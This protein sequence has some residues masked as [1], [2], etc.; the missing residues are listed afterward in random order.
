M[1]MTL[2]WVLGTVLAMVFLVVAA[3]NVW[4]VI[5]FLVKRERNSAVPLVG[6]LCGVAACFLLPVPLAG[7][8]WWLPLLLDYGSVPVFSVSAILGLVDVFRE[9]R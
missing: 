6:G 8:W 3:G 4:T 5:G 7:D 9:R 1:A 2:R